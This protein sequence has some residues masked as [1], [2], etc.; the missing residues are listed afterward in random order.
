MESQLKKLQTFLV[1]LKTGGADRNRSLQVD[2]EET[3]SEQR[4]LELMAEHRRQH[5]PEN[6]VRTQAAEPNM[7]K[8]KSLCNISPVDQKIHFSNSDLCLQ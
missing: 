4:Q 5:F 7:E 8:P 6:I 2:R 3:E 1:C